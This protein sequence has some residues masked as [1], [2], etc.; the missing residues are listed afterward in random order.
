VNSVSAPAGILVRHSPD[1]TS[2]LVID[3][4]PV[5]VLGPRS[6]A[7]E[8]PKAKAMLGD[9][10]LWLTDDQDVAP[11]RPK[12]AEQNPKYPIVD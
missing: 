9:T 12:T 6:K 1:E 8:Q 11:R 10:G 3:L 4:W 5:Q 7:P 2:N